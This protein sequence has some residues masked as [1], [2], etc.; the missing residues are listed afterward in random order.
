MAQKNL[1]PLQTPVILATLVLLG[2]LLLF[3][4]SI[5]RTVLDGKQLIAYEPQTRIYYIAA[6]ST[7]WNYAPSGMDLHTGGAVPRPWGDQTTYQKTRYFEYTDKTFTKRKPQPQWLGIL[8]PIIRGVQGDTIEVVF[9]NRADKPYSMHP[10][11]VFYDKEVDIPGMGKKNLAF[12]INNF[13]ILHIANLT[14]EI[15]A[16]KGVQGLKGYPF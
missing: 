15:S 16:A 7:E 8:G 11:G 9:Y 12:I 13:V 14:G 3:T 6:E 1:S 10:H 4:L 2:I 5:R